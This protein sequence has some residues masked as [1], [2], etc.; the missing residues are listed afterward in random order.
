MTQNNKSIQD[1]AQSLQMVVS[2][3]T[4]FKGDCVKNIHWYIGKY[5][6]GIHYYN[7]CAYCKKRQLI[8]LD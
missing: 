3:S 8:D 1:N 6:K 7:E 2:H 4:V 5:I